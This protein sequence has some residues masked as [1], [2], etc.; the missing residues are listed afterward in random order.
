[1]TYRVEIPWPLAR[2]SYQDNDGHYCI[3]GWK[4]ARKTFALDQFSIAERSGYSLVQL[5]DGRSV[6]LSDDT[7]NV[8]D[9]EERINLLLFGLLASG[10]APVIVDTKT[11]EVI[12]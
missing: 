8:E 9:M 7:H 10:Y 2:G 3:I 12:G 1:M 6:M 4:R 11:E 5:N